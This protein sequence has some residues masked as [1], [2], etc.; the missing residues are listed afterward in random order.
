MPFLTEADEGLVPVYL[1]SDN[2]LFIFLSGLPEHMNKRHRDCLLLL[3]RNVEILCV[4]GD[5]TELPKAKVLIISNMGLHCFVGCV[6][7]QNAVTY[8]Y[9]Q[10]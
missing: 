1:Q 7:S 5:I 8:R 3:R 10:T 2:K 4:V 9:E 6:V